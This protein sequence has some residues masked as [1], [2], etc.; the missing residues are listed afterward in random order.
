MLTCLICLQ[1]AEKMI[2][3]KLILG[4]TASP[5]DELLLHTHRIQPAAKN[6]VER[7]QGPQTTQMK[8][9]IINSKVKQTIIKS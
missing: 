9:L 5:D 2:A 8:C 4:I 6:K 3:S 7:T 1:H